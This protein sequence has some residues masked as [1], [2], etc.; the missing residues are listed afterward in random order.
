MRVSTNVKP[1]KKKSKTAEVFEKAEERAQQ[2]YAA[3]SKAA[4]EYDQSLKDKAKKFQVKTGRV[5]QGDL[6]ASGSYVGSTA[7]RYSEAERVKGLK[8]TGFY[9]AK[10]HVVGGTKKMLKRS[11]KN[12]KKSTA[13]KQAKKSAARLY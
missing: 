4:K 5:T 1:K 12:V 6:A 9:D 2:K 8:E 3:D 13:S 11:K 10:P 7:K